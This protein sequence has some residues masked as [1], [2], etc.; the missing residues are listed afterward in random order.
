MRALLRNNQTLGQL[1]TCSGKILVLKRIL[2]SRIGTL[3]TCQLQVGTLY[4]KD[5][6][7]VLPRRQD[8]VGVGRV[9]A[10]LF[11]SHRST[12]VGLPRNALQQDQKSLGSPRDLGSNPS[13]VLTQG[14]TLD[15]PQPCRTL[16]PLP[17]DGGRA[18][19]LGGDL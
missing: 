7:S 3:H 6:V 15:K 4:R 18:I 12:S 1:Q 13:M 2:G 5:T 16:S 14:M 9:A 17:F 8:G 11:A 10:L 19:Y